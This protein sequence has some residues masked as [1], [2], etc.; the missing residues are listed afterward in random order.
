ME[1]NI[2]ND[3]I[4]WLVVKAMLDEF[5]TIRAKAKTYLKAKK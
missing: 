3:Q 5:P 2:Q 4:R 1:V